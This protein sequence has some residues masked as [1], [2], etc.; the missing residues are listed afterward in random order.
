MKKIVSVFLAILL[1]LTTMPAYAAGTDTTAPTVSNL[2]WTN[3]TTDAPGSLE[4]NFDLVEDGVGVKE[5]SFFTV[6]RRAG[7]GKISVSFCQR[8]RRLFTGAS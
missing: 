7:N 3:N 4:L 2:S 8:K 6:R 1:L 5:I